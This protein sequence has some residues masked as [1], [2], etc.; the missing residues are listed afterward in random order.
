M[1][2]VLQIYEENLD[3][4]LGTLLLVHCQNLLLERYRSLKLEKGF[5]RTSITKQKLKLDFS[6]FRVLL[7]IF[8]YCD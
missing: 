6:I 5:Q 2:L 7:F 8:C 4:R 3:N 1:K